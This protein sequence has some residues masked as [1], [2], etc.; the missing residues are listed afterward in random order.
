MIVT[1]YECPS[2]KAVNRRGTVSDDLDDGVELGLRGVKLY[3]STGRV[4]IRESTYGR[5]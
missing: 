2:D 4:P 1:H 5:T 3:P